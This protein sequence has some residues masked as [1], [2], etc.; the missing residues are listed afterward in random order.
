MKYKIVSESV[1]PLIQ[2]GATN[3]FHEFSKFDDL[4]NQGWEVKEV[5]HNH[6]RTEN[7]IVELHM[8]LLLINPK[9][10]VS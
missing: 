5:L 10:T 2:E 8:C 3:Y 4:F 7:N 1:R 9:F 6:V